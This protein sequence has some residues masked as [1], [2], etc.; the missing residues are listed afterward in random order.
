M[1]ASFL[2]NC[3]IFVTEE[4][5]KVLARKYR[6]QNF[7]GLIG[8]EV[9]VQTIKNAILS[10]RVHHAFILT[11]MRG[12]GKTSTARIIAKALNCSNLIEQFEPC[13]Q[14]SNCQS[15]TADKHQDVI[16]ID[17]ASNTSVDNIREIIES[18]RFKPLSAKY[19]IFIIDEVHMLSKSAFNALLKTLEE[20][21]QYV[22]F[23]FATTEIRKIPPTILS[24]CQRFDLKR[25]DIQELS[26]HMSYVCELEKAKIDDE[27]LKLIAAAAKGSVRDALSMLDQAITLNSGSVTAQGTRD[28]LGMSNVLQILALFRSI[29]TGENKKALEIVKEL[30]DYGADPILILEDITH[31][32]HNITKIKVLKLQ[33]NNDLGV[34]EWQF[35]KEMS[36]KL[37]MVF[38]SRSWQMIQKGLRDLSASQFP[39]E[40]LE[41]IVIRLSLIS[42]EASIE[43]ILNALDGSSNAS[44]V[45]SA[46][47]ASN[48]NVQDHL[49]SKKKNIKLTRFDYK[50]IAD[51]ALHKE[52]FMLYHN[53]INYTKFIKLESGEAHIYFTKGAPSDLKK[54]MQQFI[55]DNCEERIVDII[56]ASD[57]GGAQ[58]IAET[59]KDAKEK[60]RMELSKD[61]LVQEV[62]NCFV[63]SKICDMIIIDN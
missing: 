8:Q 6:P 54:T 63:D 46:I 23:I 17:A 33:E 25:V 7:G 43:D 3:N 53:M 27:S 21:P 40:E 29:V 19:K 62:L 16:E 36:D 5:Y 4:H 37:D 52:E 55:N 15:I 61:A 51:L 44:A 42:T 41:M 58:T 1:Q 26:K 48:I 57:N 9:L 24:R 28:M 49:E 45:N 32:V 30:Y 60:V 39:L 38:L 11:G 31:V 13:G 10:N 14:C 22:K 2:N 35:C 59:K 47:V 20:P 18:A 34:D 56:S 50:G 12:I